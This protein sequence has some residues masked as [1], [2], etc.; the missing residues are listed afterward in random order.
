MEAKQHLA[1]AGFEP[2]AF[3]TAILK[4]KTSRADGL[5]R[6]AEAHGTGTVIMGRRGTTSV[7]E[8]SMGRV[9]RKMLY[10]AYNRA[11]WIV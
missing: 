9:T 6:E 1:G 2:K 4:E 11:L 7:E 10:L 5:C 3:H 8:F